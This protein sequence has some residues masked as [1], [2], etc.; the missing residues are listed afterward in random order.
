MS[1]RPHLLLIREVSAGNQDALG[2]A[3]ARA[4]T[5]SENA[6]ADL[7]VPAEDQELMGIL[8]TLGYEDDDGLLVA[9]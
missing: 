3:T 5:R 1:R 6:A 8:T 9:G 7:P 4:L 2:A